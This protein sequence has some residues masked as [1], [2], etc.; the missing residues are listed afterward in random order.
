MPAPGV[1]ERLATQS[2][3]GAD[4]EDI[5]KTVEGL[6]A[7]SEEQ[8]EMF[9]DLEKRRQLE[10][11]AKRENMP[12]V[13]ILKDQFHQLNPAMIHAQEERCHCV[14]IPVEEYEIQRMKDEAV[15]YTMPPELPDAKMLTPTV[16]NL[17]DFKSQ[18]YRELPR[19]LKKKKKAKRR[20][21]KQSR[22]KK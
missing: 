6:M 21:Q 18:H 15:P 19:D 17:P 12:I 22:K 5:A 8:V 16:C 4:A 20:Q 2:M 3:L 10:E 14:M 11:R 7:Q 13:Y 9:R 1:I